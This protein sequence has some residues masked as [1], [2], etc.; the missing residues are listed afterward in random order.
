MKGVVAVEWAAVDIAGGGE[1]RTS[2]VEGAD[3]FAVDTSAAL[4]VGSLDLMEQ[5]CK[6]VLLV[7]AEYS[8]V[9]SLLGSCDQ[10][11]SDFQC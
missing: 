6:L 9:G 8:P 4:V 3:T 2:A 10:E 11:I 7:E 5:C 1:L